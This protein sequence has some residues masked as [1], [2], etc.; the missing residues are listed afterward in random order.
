MVHAALWGDRGAINAQTGSWQ[1]DSAKVQHCQHWHTI[2][3]V[4]TA[5]SLPPRWLCSLSANYAF[6]LKCAPESYYWELLGDPNMHIHR[7][8]LSWMIDWSAQMK[9]WQMMKDETFQCWVATQIAEK[10]QFCGICVLL[11]FSLTVFKLHVTE[12]DWSTL[13]LLREYLWFHYLHLGFTCTHI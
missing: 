11:P 10:C 12:S 8:W 1:N 4:C 13:L 5:G 3:P 7:H 2:I 6:Q 9:V